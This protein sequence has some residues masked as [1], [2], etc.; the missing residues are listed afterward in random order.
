MERQFT[1]FRCLS[2][3][4]KRTIETNTNIRHKHI[5][6]RKLVK[7]AFSLKSQGVAKVSLPKKM[8]TK[9]PDILISFWFFL[10]TKPFLTGWKLKLQRCE[11]F[12]SSVER[13]KEK[14]TKRKQKKHWLTFIIQKGSRS[15]HK[16]VISGKLISDISPFCYDTSVLNLFWRFRYIGVRS[17]LYHLTVTIHASSPLCDPDGHHM[18]TLFNMFWVSFLSSYVHN[19]QVLVV[20]GGWHAGWHNLCDPLTVK[21]KPQVRSLSVAVIKIFV[22]VL[23]DEGWELTGRATAILKI[24]PFALPI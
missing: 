10:T 21:Y 20:L 11:T 3:H 14:Q 9:L 4:K 13:T 18:S 1:E 6:L 24:T 5:P 17:Y 15:S 16:Y 12:I 19:V 2:G 22:W 7:A 23:G 8:E